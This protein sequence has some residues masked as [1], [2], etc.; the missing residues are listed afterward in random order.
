MYAFLSFK[1]QMSKV[2]KSKLK[3]AYVCSYNALFQMCIVPPRKA[4]FNL[5]FF[6]VCHWQFRRALPHFEPVEKSKAKKCQCLMN[7]GSF[8]DRATYPFVFEHF[9]HR[10]ALVW[11]ACN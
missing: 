2:F 9:F 6:D 7:E 3:C 11:L 1:I 8:G 10:S 5:Q 4:A